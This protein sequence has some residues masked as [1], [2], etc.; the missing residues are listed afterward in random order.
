MATSDNGYTIE[1]RY[2]VSGDGERFA[3]YRVRGSNSL[4]WIPMGLHVAHRAIESGLFHGCRVEQMA[5]VVR[6][7]A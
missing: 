1:I 6:G 2:W 5:E 3:Q 4:V 7:A